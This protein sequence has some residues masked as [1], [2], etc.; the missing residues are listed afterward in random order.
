[1]RNRLQGGGRHGPQLST[2]LPRGHPEVSEFRGKLFQVRAS[3]EESPKELAEQDS[4]IAAI[5]E[6]DKR[7]HAI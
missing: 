3:P 4:D 7:K 2:C 6:I 5:A 1:M